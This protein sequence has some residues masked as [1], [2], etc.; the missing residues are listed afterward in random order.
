[1]KKMFITTI[2]LAAL[3]TAAIA[4]PAPPVGVDEPVQ[5]SYLGI[6]T[7]RK[8]DTEMIVH[9]WVLCIAQSYAERLLL[10]EKAGL[11]AAHDAYVA[12][13]NEQMCGQFASMRVILESLLPLSGGYTAYEARVELSGVW[14]NAFVIDVEGITLELK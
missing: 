13:K 12:L 9:G 2:A 7:D 1:M 4:H 10:A 3:C 5:S 8:L 6:P 14:A 11:K